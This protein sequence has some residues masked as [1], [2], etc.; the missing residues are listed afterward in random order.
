MMCFGK[1]EFVEK[2]GE[3][4]FTKMAIVP[5]YMIEIRRALKLMINTLAQLWQPQ[6]TQLFFISLSVSISIST[7]LSRT[8][9]FFL[10]LFIIHSLY[11]SLYLLLFPSLPLLPT[12]TLS[13]CAGTSKIRRHT[14]QT[15]T[16][17]T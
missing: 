12:H 1:L 13:S 10:S 14:Q 5:M 4:D 3:Y 17:G 15:E 9:P 8:L 6:G 7:T 16:S 11:L 2:N